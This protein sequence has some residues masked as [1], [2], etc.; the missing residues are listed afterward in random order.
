MNRVKR[1]RYDKS[2]VIVIKQTEYSEQINWSI[3]T[4]NTWWI[5]KSF[6]VYTHWQLYFTY[7][8]LNHRTPLDL[9]R[10]EIHFLFFSTLH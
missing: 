3:N 9:T 1:N 4:S 7:L 5:K 2:A 8:D 10:Q 6:P